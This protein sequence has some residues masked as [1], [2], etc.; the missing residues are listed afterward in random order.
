MRIIYGGQIDKYD[1][2]YFGWNSIFMKQFLTKAGFLKHEKVDGFGLFDDT[3]N[4]K[5]YG[6]PVSLNIS[7]SSSAFFVT[8]A[9]LPAPAC[10]SSNVKGTLEAKSIKP[11][12]DLLVSFKKISIEF[13]LI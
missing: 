10:I 2:H 6:F 1:F 12:N 7:L 4:Y 3:S 5:P 11:L 9:R 8:T 13:S